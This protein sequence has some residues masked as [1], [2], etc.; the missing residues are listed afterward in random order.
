M[1]GKKSP[2]NKMP[3]D[4]WQ[5][6]A[7]L[8]VLFGYMMAHPGKKPLFMGGEFGQFDEWKDLEDL[9]WEMLGYDSHRSMHRYVR[10]LNHL[11]LREPAL[12]KLDHRPEGFSW[13][14]P[15]DSKQSITTFMRKTE[16]PEDSLIAV[17]NFTPVYHEKYR[18]GVP[19]EGVYVEQFSSDAGEYGGSG[20]LN[21]GKLKTEAVSWHYQPYSLHISLPPLAAVLFKPIEIKR[22]R[23]SVKTRK[24]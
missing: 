12:W 6:F 11:Y 21:S 23:G 7:N 3:G 15:H 1:H 13:I 20:K 16:N 17:C 24:G 14:D 22:R 2:L 5:K 10:D 8:R 18:I 19:Y 9:D 4:Y